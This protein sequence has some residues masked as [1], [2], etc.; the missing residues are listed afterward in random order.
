MVFEIMGRPAEHIVSALNQ[1]IDR[2]AKEQGANVIERKIHDPI[3]V[4]DS[5]DLFTTFAETVVSF[6]SVI[7]CFRIIFTYL[8][9]NIEIISPEHIKF[10]NDDLTTLAN[11]FA[12]RLHDYD[13]IAKR[14]VSEREALANNLQ[15]AG[16]LKKKDSDKKKD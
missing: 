1:L 16:L 4:K 9:A 12:A 6:D 13:A 15:K 3:P 5:K 11:A 10:R 2:I 14:L 8:P 7:S